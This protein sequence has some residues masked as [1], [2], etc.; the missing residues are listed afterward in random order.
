MRPGRLARIIFSGQRRVKVQAHSRE[1]NCESETFNPFAIKSKL[2][3]ETFL[4][5]PPRPPGNCG[6]C[7]LARECQRIAPLV[8]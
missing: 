3:M 7:L 5:P 6:Q 1:N 8:H 4:F 2:R